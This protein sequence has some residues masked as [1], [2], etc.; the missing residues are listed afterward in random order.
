MTLL[1]TWVFK[2]WFCAYLPHSNG[3]IEYMSLPKL[4][5]FFIFPYSNELIESGLIFVFAHGSTFLLDYEILLILGA[6]ILLRR[7]EIFTTCE[8]RVNQSLTDRAIQ[9]ECLQNPPSCNLTKC[10]SRVIVVRSDLICIHVYFQNTVRISCVFVFTWTYW[11]RYI[12]LAH[13]M[14]CSY[15]ASTKSDQDQTLWNNLDT[16]KAFYKTYEYLSESHTNWEFAIGIIAFPF[17]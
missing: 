4:S 8:V 17:R 2:R 7:H 9:L 16:L 13:P 12:F 5:S 11:I 1:N 10:V 6:V 3:L 14:L 15:N